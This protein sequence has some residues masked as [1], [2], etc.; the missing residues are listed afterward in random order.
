MSS[1]LPA[2]HMRSIQFIHKLFSYVLQW[3]TFTI[4]EKIRTPFPLAQGSGERRPSID[5]PRNRSHAR[6]L[7]ATVITI[8]GRDPLK[9][10]ELAE[11]LFDEEAKLRKRPI[12]KLIFG[13]TVLAARLATG[14]KT[15]PAQLG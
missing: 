2:H 5:Q 11:G 14:R 1:K 10:S 15:H 4:R 6:P 13:R 8:R 9:A 3:L 7:L 12:V